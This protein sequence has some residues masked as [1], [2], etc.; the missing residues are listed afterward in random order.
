MAAPSWSFD[1][2]LYYQCVSG[3]R[4][5]RIMIRRRNLVLTTHLVLNLH[6]GNFL[7]SAA[8]FEGMEVIIFII[9]IIAIFGGNKN[10]ESSSKSANR[11]KQRSF[12]CMNCGAS[13]YQTNR[14][15]ICPSCGEWG[16]FT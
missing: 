3:F 11:P 7:S 4:I 16:K 5:V 13:Q 14:P 2:T 8:C 10:K 6:S 1:E 12:T 15:T 9:I